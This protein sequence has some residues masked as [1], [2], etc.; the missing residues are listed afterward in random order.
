MAVDAIA[1][2]A[3]RILV[4]SQGNQIIRMVHARSKDKLLLFADLP[5]KGPFC[6][7]RPHAKVKIYIARFRNLRVYNRLQKVQVSMPPHTV[8]NPD[9]EAIQ[10]GM[11]VEDILG[12][13]GD[14][15]RMITKIGIRTGEVLI[16]VVGH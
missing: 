6:L 13:N 10:L 15:K 4:R 11:I 3:D 16:R 12:V 1:R 7:I 14:D 9:G 5:T 8:R 2:R